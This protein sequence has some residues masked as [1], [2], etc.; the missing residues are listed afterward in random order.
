MKR[1]PLSRF[2]ICLLYILLVHADRSILLSQTSP[3]A[4]GIPQEEQLER[5]SASNGKASDGTLL[6]FNSYRSAHRVQ[7]STTKGRFKSPAAAQREFS[8][9]LKLSK[10]VMERRLLEDASGNRVG[11]RAVAVFHD[12]DTETEYFAVLWTNG[13]NYYWVSSASLELALNVEKR[14]N[15]DWK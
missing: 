2:A 4:A 9:S 6:S 8:V 12:P 15:T 13:P 1:P 14:L 10:K 7:V 11:T 5:I 3:E